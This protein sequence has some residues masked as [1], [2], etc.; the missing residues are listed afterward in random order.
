[1]RAVVAR[2]LEER[3][4]RRGGAGG[5]E[6]EVEGQA[7]RGV[8]EGDVERERERGEEVEQREAEQLV[9]QQRGPPHAHPRHAARPSQ[10]ARAD[11][12]IEWG[13]YVRATQFVLTL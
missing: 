3:R 13:T 9:L 6:E 7:A 2:V 5:A 1:M 8:G 10:S 12:R 11:R 4:R